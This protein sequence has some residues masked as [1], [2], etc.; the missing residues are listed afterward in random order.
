MMK[1]PLI[2]RKHIREYMV[3]GFISAVAYSIFVWLFL[4]DNKYENFYLLY[5]GNTALML[6]MGIYH[7]ILINR[8]YEGKRSVAMMIAGSFMLVTAIVM[9]LIILTLLIVA[10]HPDVFARVPQDAI[11]QDAPDNVPANR[12]TSLLFMIGMNTILVNLAAGSL[13]SVLFAYAGKRNQVKDQ[14][15]P[16]HNRI[17]PV[18]KTTH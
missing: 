4:R 17:H 3:Y 9:S 7:Y 2:D 1:N 15:T 16:T 18:S 8:Q 11:V 5:I 10:Y 6:I 13:V 14:P 12:P